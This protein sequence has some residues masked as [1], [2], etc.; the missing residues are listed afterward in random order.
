[1]RMI[2]VAAAILVCAEEVSV[3]M[4]CGAAVIFVSAEEVS[5]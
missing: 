1:M 2:S 4:I 5:V 3:R